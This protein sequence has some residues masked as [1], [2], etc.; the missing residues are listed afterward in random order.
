MDK[1]VRETAPCSR[2]LL[3]RNAAVAAAGLVAFSASANRAEAKAAQNLVGYQDQPHGAQ[4]CDNC[5]QF[6]APS[7]CKVVDGTISP[8]GWCK[9]YVKKP[10]S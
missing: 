7:A 6:Q 5:L 4:Q 10:G 9:V 3:L 8:T 1:D 2:R